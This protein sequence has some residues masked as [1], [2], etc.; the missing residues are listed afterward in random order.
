MPTDTTWISED[1]GIWFARKGKRSARIYD[2]GRLGISVAL[3]P[4]PGVKLDDEFDG[5]ESVEEAKKRVGKWL[6]RGV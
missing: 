2:A 4:S 5:F 6:K 3:Y 1:D